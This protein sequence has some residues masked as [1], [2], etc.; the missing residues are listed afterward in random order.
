MKSLYHGGVQCFLLFI[1]GSLLNCGLAAEVA[2]RP[3]LFKDS[4]AEMAKARAAGLQD[5]ALVIASMPGKNFRVSALL[6]EL[7][8]E[9]QYR[10]DDV[11]YLRVRLP[12]DAVE[13][14]VGNA[15]V[16]SV[17]VSL[18]GEKRAFSFTAPMLST[19][20]SDA[21]ASPAPADDDRSDTGAPWPP[22]FSDHPF[23]DRYSPLQDMRAKGFLE[24]NPTYDGRVVRIGMIDMNADPLLP[25][26]QQAMS[27]DGKIVPKIVAY[28]TAMDKDHEDD[29]R[30][31]DM[32]DT[33]TTDTDR[34]SYKG[35]TYTAPR[36]GTFR[37]GF[38]DEE[39]VDANG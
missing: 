37:I 17:D 26:L 19:P 12:L 25:E 21:P 38:Y 30:W 2:R 13:R 23:S 1:V 14:L 16:H 20:G 34:F 9:I 36:A 7:G 28:E 8:G 10:D 4:R 5:I 35:D 24:S 27:L 29:G 33:V 18:R 32:A 15:N 3:F 22:K 11:D 6:S 31:V 39:K